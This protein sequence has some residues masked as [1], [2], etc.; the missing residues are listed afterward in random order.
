[1]LP[2]IIGKPTL[3]KNKMKKYFLNVYIFFVKVYVYLKYSINVN[4]YPCCSA[5]PAHTTFADAPIKVPLPPRQAPRANA[6]TNGCSGKSKSSFS[7]NDITTF[8]IIVVNGMLSTKAE[9][10]ADTC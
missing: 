8:T 7:A 10:I 5:T 9:A 4:R 1:M 3:K 6:H 2:I